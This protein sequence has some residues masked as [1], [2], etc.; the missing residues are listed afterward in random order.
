MLLVSDRFKLCIGLFNIVGSYADPL[1][2]HQGMQLSVTVA[3]GNGLVFERLL[4]GDHDA[5]LFQ[6]EP[7]FVQPL[8]GRRKTA[9]LLA[10]LPF[11]G[12]T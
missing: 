11:A 12:A 8:R 4:V 3:Q 7:V 9:A 5:H 1:Q 2:A 10:A 6:H